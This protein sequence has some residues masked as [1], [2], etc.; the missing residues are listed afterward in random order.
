LTSL[1]AKKI[2]VYSFRLL[3]LPVVR[4]T[5]LR[6]KCFPIMLKRSVNGLVFA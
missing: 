2:H 6:A 1:W 5:M 4:L 3:L